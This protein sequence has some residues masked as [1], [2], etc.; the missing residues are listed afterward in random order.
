MTEATK[1]TKKATAPKAVEKTASD[2]RVEQLEAQL[3]ALMERL[4]SREETTVE[5][6]SSPEKKEIAS[7]DYITVMS[8][9]PQTLILSTSK[10][11]DGKQ[12]VFHSFGE[13]MPIIYSEL[14]DIVN[15][16]RRFAER[17]YFYIMDMRA[18]DHLGLKTIYQNLL[19]KEKMEEIIDA[20]DDSV[21]ALFEATNKGQQETIIDVLIE[22]IRDNK[23]AV[24]LNVIDRIS[25]ITG[26]NI[27]EKAED[28]KF[29]ADLISET[30]KEK[31]D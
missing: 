22:K 29:L 3:Q 8:L 24:N 25:R 28:A 17:G 5:P 26:T 31:Q 11:G 4:D 20:K 19:T 12:K 2:L 10:R 16:D 18:V 1:T 27:V 30:G 13:T 15:T 21:V 9:V 14:V 23:D 7:T 6:A